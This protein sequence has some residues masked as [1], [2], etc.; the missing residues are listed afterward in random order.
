MFV[1]AYTAMVVR[2][3]KA[4]ALKKV[5]AKAKVSQ[6][7][8]MQI[9]GAPGG[10]GGGAGGGGGSGGGGSNVHPVSGT[11]YA[12]GNSTGPL[13][14]AGVRDPGAGGGP[15]LRNDP[16]TDR[17]DADIE[18][19][20]ASV[21]DLET[22]HQGT[23]QWASRAFVTPDAIAGVQR[24][25]NDLNA[26][27]LQEFGRAREY[28]DT[29]QSGQANLTN[30]VDDL[31]ARA[32]SE[33]QRVHGSVRAV[34]GGV[35]AVGSTIDSLAAA[36]G[37][38]FQA[39]SA[40]Q[41]ELAEGIMNVG[42][43]AAAA[44]AALATRTE[45]AL[46]NVVDAIRAGLQQSQEN[47]DALAQQAGGA[48]QHL[49]AGQ[50][51]LGGNL[52]QLAQQAGSA[53]GRAATE[54]QQLNS[55]LQQLNGAQANMAAQGSHALQNLQQQVNGIGGAVQETHRVGGQI[56]N[57][58]LQ[59]EAQ[60]AAMQQQGSGGA[61]G[62]NAVA[63]AYV[64]APIAQQPYIQNVAASAP[65]NAQ[66]ADNVGAMVRARG[67]P[68]V[69]APLQIGDGGGGG[70]L[71]MAVM[72]AQPAIRPNPTVGDVSGVVPSVGR[73]VVPLAD[74]AMDYSDL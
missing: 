8:K 65:T 6:V 24:A 44:R 13:G 66:L 71:H 63:R 73:A 16:R 31:H 60:L 37:A 29:L 36:T 55:G 3:K 15:M 26:D 59:N 61:V 52:Q 54:R 12:G 22:A 21:G 45:Q 7:V 23:R 25:V 50:Q 2:K 68:T 14:G 70:A 41:Q 64:A 62:E 28:V 46:G 39:A 10:G 19:L 34:A 47:L 18:R 9:V 27:T 72:S 49:A 35:G 17:H 57:R 20:L 42:G 30:R 5:K 40:G 67:G 1:Y 32:A 74:G 56:V 69:H 58:I 53:I 51:Q 11:V 33:F 43:E 48:V 4:E 38:A